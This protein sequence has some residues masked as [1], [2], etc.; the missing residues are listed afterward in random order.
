[1]VRDADNVQESFNQFSDI[2]NNFYNLHY[3]LKTFKFNK[4]IDKIEPWFTNGL[5]ISRKTKFKL[6]SIY[7]R[8]P[9]VANKLKFNA[10]RNLYN[11][12]LCTAKKSYF[13]LEFGKN[14]SNLKKTWELIR[15]AMNAKQTDCN[16][17]FIFSN[18]IKHTKPCDIAS[19]LNAFFI[20]APSKIAQNIPATHEPDIK[21]YNNIS[22][23]LS[24]SPVTM[25]E[26]SDATKQLL[27]KKSED[28]YGYSMK[29]IKRFY[30]SIAT[31]LYYIF[32]KSF[33]TGEIPSQ[34]KIA[35]V[36]PIFKSGDP[37]LPNNYRP[38]SLLPNISKILEKVMCNRLT[39][40]LE[41]NNLLANSQYGFRKEHSTVHPLVHFLNNLT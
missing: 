1:M 16:I 13:D 24:A 32:S 29:F 28:M 18:G 3:P 21:F 15:Q 17:P 14:I 4:N 9:T 5:L 19:E 39:F 31:P 25:T 2:F 41:S 40:F 7:S 26:I 22:F 34:L 11:R 35:K 37:S 36:V 10:Y 12:L 23:N 38:I 8:T 6:S 20:S 27:P 30:S 33:E